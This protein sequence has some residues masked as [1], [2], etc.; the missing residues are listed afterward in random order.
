MAGDVLST[1]WHYITAYFLTTGSCNLYLDGVLKSGATGSPPV[2][3]SGTD[4]LTI[5]RT[6]SYSNDKEYYGSI[7]EVRVENVSRTAA[8]VKL[9]YENQRQDQT[10][11]KYW[12]DSAFTYRLKVTVQG[13]QVAGTVTQ[14]PVYVNLANLGS[15][16]WSNVVSS[17]NI[18]V[19]AGNGLTKLPREVVS[20]TDAGSTGTGELWFQA[21]Q[22]DAGQER[23]LLRLFRRLG[24]RHQQH[25]RLVQRVQRGLAH[26]VVGS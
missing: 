4:N 5:G 3:T 26:A 2:I 6:T 21:P 19:T 24:D 16:F 20:F 18:V 10:L 7:D 22:L 9:C 23:Q 8:W 13:T 17:S 12:Y 15:S 1:G 11:I 25:G 14:F